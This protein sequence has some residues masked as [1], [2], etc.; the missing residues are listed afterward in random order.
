MV[1]IPQTVKVGELGVAILP[2]DSPF[3]PDEVD[4]SLEKPGHVS[5]EGIGSIS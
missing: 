5:T 1:V 4:M 3:S 2:S